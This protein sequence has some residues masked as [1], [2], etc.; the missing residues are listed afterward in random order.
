VP[1]MAVERERER[2]L[3][4]AFAIN[5]GQRVA[6]IC[7]TRSGPLQKRETTQVCNCESEV[8]RTRGPRRVR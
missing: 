6:G 4:M 1:R 7:A 3:G 2:N 8:Y 5:P